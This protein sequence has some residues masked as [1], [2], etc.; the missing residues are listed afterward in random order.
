MSALT[1]LFCDLARIPSPSL[2][3][4]AVAEHI[5]SVF[6]ENNIA[7]ERDGFGNVCAR[8][9]ATDAATAS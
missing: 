9:P 8:V 1:D 6:K 2:R 7:A 3:E 4:D 5:L